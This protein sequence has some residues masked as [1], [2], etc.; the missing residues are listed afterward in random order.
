MIIRPST[1]ILTVGVPG[2]RIV[3]PGGGALST[4]WNGWGT[5]PTANCLAA[6]L[7]KGAASYVASK[8]NL[9]TPG[10]HDLADGAAFPTWAA[11]TGWTFASASSQYLAADFGLQAT[12]TG[13]VRC[14]AWSGFNSVAFGAQTA[15]SH[16]YWIQTQQAGGVIIWYNRSSTNEATGVVTDSVLAIAG[17]TPYRNAVAKAGL[18]GIVGTTTNVCVGA[19][20]NSVGNPV[21][22][23]NGQISAIAFY[24]TA[25]SAA[26]IATLTAAMAAL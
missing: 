9:V 1:R 18:T 13:I 24:D 2:L 23:Y 12:Y 10:T 4:W 25:L 19:V 7:A 17:L 15:G 5:I 11:G 14:A 8:A 20:R 3:Q 21:Q 26:Q 16:T 22:F 6:H